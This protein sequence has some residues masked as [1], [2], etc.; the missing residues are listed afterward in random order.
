[1]PFRPWLPT[2]FAGALIL[3]HPTQAQPLP[4]LQ[5]AL[6][7][8]IDTLDPT[9]AR[10]YSGRFVFAALCDKLFDI[11]E[12]LAIVPQLATSYEWVSP[13]TLL[14]RLRAGVLFHDG[15]K[16]DAAAVVAS[17]IRHL[18]LPGSTRRSEISAMAGAEAVDPLT[19]RVTLKSPSA[20]FLSQLTDRAGMIV[21]P[22]AA[23]AAGTNFALAPV[24]TGPFRFVER[25]AQDR[26]V[27]DRFDKYWDA[28]NIHFSR[29]TYRP[30]PDNAVKLANLQAGVIHIA[31]RVAPTDI[32]RARRDPR[33]TVAIY[34]GLGYNAINFNVANGKHA[35]TP[36]GRSALV[37]KAFELAIDRKALVDV[38]Y[39]GAFTPVAQA[40]SPSNPLYNEALPPPSRDVAQA[41]ALL[42]KAGVNPPVVVRLTVVNS[43]DQVQLAEVIQSMASE[44]GFDV[45]VVATEFAAALAAQTGGD[46]EA[47][48]IGWSGRIDPDGNLYN[49]LSSGGALNETHYV[50]ADVDRW[51]DAARVTSEPAARKALYARITQQIAADVPVMYLY[52]TA[53]VVGMSAKL[54]GFRPVPDGLIRLQGL[55]MAP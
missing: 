55:L 35:D 53:L 34:P 3:G 44:A 30:I 19:V 22:T 29:V 33:L 46:Y 47:S 21:S 20:P 48:T 45:R 18:T 5:I 10:T 41:R 49:A 54:R 32:D 28:G 25:V 15:T 37:R 42:A 31:E 12:K 51:L 38:V 11:D 24:C 9:I 50:N 40:M 7:D 23:A 4:A 52:N 17:L 2:L 8:D 27:L 13:T 39:N 36:L 26:I 6:A 1:M 14:L 43:P 16:L